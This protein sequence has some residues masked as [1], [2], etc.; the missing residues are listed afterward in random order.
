[1]NTIDREMS[2]QAQALFDTCQTSVLESE[3]MHRYTTNLHRHLRMYRDKLKDEKSGRL[4][5]EYKSMDVPS[6]VDPSF[7][8]RLSDGDYKAKAQIFMSFA[9]KLYR[10]ANYLVCLEFLLNVKFVSLS[11]FLTTIF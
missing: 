2:R 10:S 6:S 8:F 7:A 3:L 11:S 5:K 4:F 1:M 9:E